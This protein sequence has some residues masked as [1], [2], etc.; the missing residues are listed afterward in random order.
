MRQLLTRRYSN[1]NTLPIGERVLLAMSVLANDFKVREKGTNAG[2]WVEA[3]LD[4]SGL[5]AGYPW[6]AAA[7][8]FACEI[9]QTDI[10]PTKSVAAVS[11]WHKW[12]N[13]ANRLQSSPKRGHLC[14]WLNPNGT[15]H[16][17]IVAGVAATRVT[18]YEGNTSSSEAGSQRDGDGLYRRSRASGTWKYYV[19]LN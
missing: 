15:G 19:E 2:P 6:C 14:L 4:C 1:Y 18:T 9:A 13:A 17:G 7:I 3:I 5:G 8:N 11:A 16:I 10:G 12:A